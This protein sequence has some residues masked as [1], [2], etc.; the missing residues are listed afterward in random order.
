[1]YS[2]TEAGKN[3]NTWQG[4]E[5]TFFKRFQLLNRIKMA[6]DK[7]SKWKQIKYVSFFNKEFLRILL[8]IPNISEEEKIDRYFRALKPYVWKEMCTKD[9]NELSKA[10]ADAE[11]LEEAH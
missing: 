7:L 10:M 3:I 11:R 4:L 2:I 5:E 8:E 1:M 6:R 9:Y